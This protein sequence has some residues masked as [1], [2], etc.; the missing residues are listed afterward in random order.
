ME[1]ASW[2]N[3]RRKCRSDPNFCLFAALIRQFFLLLQK[4][5]TRELLLAAG[6]FTA[7][8]FA[9]AAGFR[10]HAATGAQ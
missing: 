2:R 9:A 5:R 8:G 6:L 4:L 7:A 3:P 1:G 10:L